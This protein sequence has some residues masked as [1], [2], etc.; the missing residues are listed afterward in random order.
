MENQT[1]SNA[2]RIVKQ[3]EETAGKPCIEFSKEDFLSLIF[4]NAYISHA[5]FIT[6]RRY[7]FDVLPKDSQAYQNVMNITYTSLNHTAVYQSEF[8]ACYDDMIDYA[9][10]SVQKTADMRNSD[11]HVFDTTLAALSLA[12]CGIPIADS[13]SLQKSALHEEKPQLLVRANV[14]QDIPERAHQFLLAYIQADGFFTRS[15]FRAWRPYVPSAFILRTD[16]SMQLNPTAIRVAITRNIPV[17]EK[18][19]TYDSIYW[20]GIFSRAH[21]YEL[22][23]GRIDDPSRKSQEDRKIYIQLL[24]KLFG[25]SKHM[26]EWELFSRLKQYRAY[27]RFFFPDVESSV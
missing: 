4:D 14:W 23:H 3:A 19:I 11:V 18:R 1:D 12:W 24:T 17:G 8:F 27:Q 16:R 2:K 22:Q 21:A 15:D 13:I 26:Y 10:S 7:L 20:S 25:E 6:L 5:F 9:A